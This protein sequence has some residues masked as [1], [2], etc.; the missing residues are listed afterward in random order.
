MYAEVFSGACGALT[1]MTCQ[2]SNGNAI[3]VD[4]LTAGSTYFI[5]VMA[6]D[7]GAFRIA[8]KP[9]L[10]NDEC[11]GATALPYST[12]ADFGAIQERENINAANGTGACGAIRDS[13][14]KFTAAHTSAAFIAP[15]ISGPGVGV[16]LLS[17][18]CGAL[19]SINCQVD[20]A[21]VRVRYTGLTVGA[22][23]LR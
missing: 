18:T 16:E 1:S 21:N 8:V 12:L 15:G 4:G 11:A 13:W 19:N 3:P 10:V 17:G 23:A 2:Q 20:M 5:R 9:A 6:G 7:Q 22:D 14:F